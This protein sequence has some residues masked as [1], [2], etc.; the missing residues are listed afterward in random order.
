M[1]NINYEVKGNTLTITVDLS[2]DHG[3][4]KSEKSNIVASSEG[5]KPL[6]GTDGVQFGLNVFKALPKK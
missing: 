6:D 4:S 2:Q 1:K 5:I 3:L